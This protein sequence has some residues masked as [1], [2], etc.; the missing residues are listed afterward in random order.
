MLSIFG[1]GMQA[2]K[3][4]EDNDSSDR[5]GLT[6]DR[7]D[8]AHPVICILG[9][10]I[11]A[12]LVFA[13]LDLLQGLILHDMSNEVSRALIFSRGFLATLSGMLYVYQT[14]KAKENELHLLR[15]ELAKELSRKRAALKE[16]MFSLEEEKALREG[17]SRT[18]HD[19]RRDIILVLN[20]RLRTP[21]IANQRTI[22]LLQE[23]AFGPTEGEQLEILNLLS[24]NNKEICR[25]LSMLSTLYA[26]QTGSITLEFSE[27]DLG[28]MLER[29]ASKLKEESGK[30]VPE[31]SVNVEDGARSV[32]C[33]E[34]QMETM[35]HHLVENAVKYAQSRVRVDIVRNGDSDVIL[36]INNDGKGIEEE[37]IPNLFSRFFQMSAK[38][39]YAAN[40]GV[41][42]CLC[43]EIAR[44]HNG[45]ISCQSTAE[46]GTT[47]KVRLPLR[48][49]PAKTNR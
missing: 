48:A 16:S 40:T 33:D 10:M 22:A 29:I 9:A 47:F 1:I 21:V 31:L 17:V 27:T 49:R 15:R 6:I 13:L 35:I 4:K 43:A 42:L 28:S 5:E 8:R 20:H 32:N 30:G 19:Q 7:L 11:V 36:S 18:L 24:D 38:G 39:K 14:M 34:E 44:A 37:D 3:R 46:S 12:F 25:I 41:G 23:G 2:V 26:Y 45:E